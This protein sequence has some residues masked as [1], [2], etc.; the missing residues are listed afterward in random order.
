[1]DGRV[2]KRL[3]AYTYVITV[4]HITATKL[5][6]NVNMYHIAPV[7]WMCTLVHALVKHAMQYLIMQPAH[8]N[9]ALQCYLRLKSFTQVL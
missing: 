9:I 7:A 5:L 8:Q 6:P 2:N 4:W 1:M 3:K